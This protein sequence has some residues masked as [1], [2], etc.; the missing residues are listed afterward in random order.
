MRDE[1]VFGHSFRNGGWTTDDEIEISNRRARTG[2]TDAREAEL[3][4]HAA[5]EGDFVATDVGEK[6][7]DGS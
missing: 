7:V 2:T 4:R 6:P 5:C 3:N 1:K